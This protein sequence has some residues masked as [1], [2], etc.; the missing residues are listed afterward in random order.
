MRL[1]RDCSLA[2][3]LAGAACRWMGPPPG[4]KIY[5]ARE[6]GLTLIYENPQLEPQARKDERLQVRVAATKETEAGTA[7]RTTYTS[8]KGED[9]TLT[10]QKKGGVFLSQDGQTPG[11]VVMPAGFPDQVA[12]WELRGTTFRVLGRATADLHGLKLPEIADKV[13]VW[14]ESQ[15]PQGL[16]QR[17]FFLPE[18]GEVETLVWREG[19]W[20]SINRLV[21]RGFTDAPSARE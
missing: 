9:S 5:A 21:S 13:G 16:R 4:E 19:A 1:L 6:V 11:L 7:V 12:L 20:L 15:T 8:L 17:T 2:L 10:F 18:I 14:V 3:L